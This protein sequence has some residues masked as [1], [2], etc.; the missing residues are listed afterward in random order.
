VLRRTGWKGQHTDEPKPVDS[1]D[2]LFDTLPGDPGAHGR[3]DAQSR[4]ST[5]WTRLRL[6][7]PKG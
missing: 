4:G 2:I 1:P 5:L 3:F 6:L 7:L